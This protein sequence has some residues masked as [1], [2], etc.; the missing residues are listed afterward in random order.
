MLSYSCN[1][2]SNL[3]R[4]IYTA[5]LVLILSVCITQAPT[6]NIFHHTVAAVSYLLFSDITLM[7]HN[8]I[9]IADK[10]MCIPIC[11]WRRWCQGANFLMQ[12]SQY[13]VDT[14]NTLAVTCKAS[15]KQC[16]TRARH[17]HTPCCRYF[18]GGGWVL[19]GNVS[20]R[21]VAATLASECKATVVAV[22]YALAP[23]HPYPA[24]LEDSWAAVQWAAQNAGTLE[25]L[26]HPFI[27][28]PAPPPPPPSLLP[29]MAGLLYSGL[30]RRQV[31]LSC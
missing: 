14:I 31:H 24:G 30:P 12:Q 1:A 27:S 28:I 17:L 26:V 10:P 22:D 6:R 21:A 23:E 4:H 2:F 29:Q 19:G 3:V 9:C 13:I 5:H 25:L 20:H 15:D 18:H 8:I 7:P 16:L 11:F